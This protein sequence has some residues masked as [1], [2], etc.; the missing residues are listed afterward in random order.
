MYIIENASPLSFT[1]SHNIL[2]FGRMFLHSCCFFSVFFASAGLL[3]YT[4]LCTLKWN[5]HMPKLLQ[6]AF[7]SQTYFLTIAFKPNLF[8][9]TG[10]FS[11]FVK[12]PQIY[13]Y[14]LLLLDIYMRYC[15]FTFLFTYR[16]IYYFWCKVIGV[17]TNKCSHVTITTVKIQNCSLTLK[18]SLCCPF[19]VNPFL[20]HQ[21]LVVT[22]LFSLLMILLFLEYHENGNIQDVAPPPHP[23]SPRPPRRLPP[24]PRLGGPIGAVAAWL[25]HINSGYEQ[26][27]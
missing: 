4:C 7:L 26:H 12:W 6:L 15:L 17:L 18:A 20:Y 3:A 10:I 25:H 16:K 14:S 24:V 5:H 13:L 2:L 9:L 23:R 27:L 11:V 8:F 22:D 19:V 21:P 1:F